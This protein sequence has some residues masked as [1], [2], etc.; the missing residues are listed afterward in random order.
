MLSAVSLFIVS[1]ILI[2]LLGWVPI[3]L[4]WIIM[5][6]I[7]VAFLAVLGKR[8]TGEKI[9]RILIGGRLSG[10]LI[11]SRYKMSLSRLQIIL[12]TVLALSALSVIALDRAIP[13][14]QKKVPAIAS[15][16]APAEGEKAATP[17][18]PLN[19]KFPNELL[20]A[21]GISTASLA[22]AS[23]IKS[24]KTETQS[25]KTMQLLNDQITNLEKKR[26]EEKANLDAAKKALNDLE[27]ELRIQRAIPSTDA[28]FGKAQVK[29]DQ[30]NKETI[31]AEEQKR[32]RAEK[33]W[34][35][36]MNELEALKKSEAGALGDVHTNDRIEQA[37]W[38]DIFRGELVSNYR[39]VDPAKVQMFFFTILII[40]VYGTLVWG[41]LGTE[42]VWQMAETVAL[43][44]FSDSLVA[45]LGI[46]HAG[47]LVVKQAGS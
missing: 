22:G 47:Y 10:I 9:G 25:S 16:V 37:D 5:L 20:I 24:A 30:I 14:L 42:T 17:F 13:V 39:V 34:Q 1:T 23:F 32:A 27:N 41:L 29:I 19:I 15:L 35:T 4:R 38:S 43:P 12:W 8:V 3:Q 21:M 44:P 18:D 11:D 2:G 46:S 40:F 33:I 26:D 45:L 6:V 31:P 36:Y 28:E 7:F